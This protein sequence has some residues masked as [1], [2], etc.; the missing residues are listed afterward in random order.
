MFSGIIA[1]LKSAGAHYESVKEDTNL[2]AAFHAA[3]QNLQL[4]SQAV[5]AAQ[6]KPGGKSP[7]AVEAL[8]SC[9]V[10]AER[11]QEIFTAVTEAPKASRLTEYQSAVKQ[12]DEEQT[13]EGLVVGMM[14]DLSS[15]AEDLAIQGHVEGHER[16]HQKSVPGG[17]SAP[18]ELAADLISGVNVDVNVSYGSGEEN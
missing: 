5:K 17:P 1:A 2:P 14:K 18:K 3:G 6:S 7:R 15:V 4:V 9:K 16:G 13:V 8:N 12:K 10:K 11:A